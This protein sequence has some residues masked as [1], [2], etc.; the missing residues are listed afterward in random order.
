GTILFDNRTPAVG[1]F[2]DCL[3][4]ANPPPL[5]A[6]FGTHS[7]QGV[8][9]AVGVVNVIQVGP[10]FGTEPSPSYG[11]GRVCVEFDGAAILDLGDYSACIGAIMWTD[12][13]N[14]EFGHKNASKVQGEERQR[15]TLVLPLP[16]SRLPNPC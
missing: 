10:N 7:A 2:A 6:P 11:M 13:T 16:A 1:N 9:Q 8:Q 14:E 3:L 4:P 15:G 12:A 5:A